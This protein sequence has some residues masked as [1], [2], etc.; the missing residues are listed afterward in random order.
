MEEHTESSQVQSEECLQS[1][2]THPH[3]NEVHHSGMQYPQLLM[4]LSRIGQA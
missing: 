3:S 2:D 4:L 1:E